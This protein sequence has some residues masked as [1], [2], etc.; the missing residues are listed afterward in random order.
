M[1]IVGDTSNGTGPGSYAHRL[2]GDLSKKV[3]NFRTLFA[4]NG[5]EAD[6]AVSKELVLQVKER[7]ENTVYGFFLDKRLVYPV[8]VYRFLEI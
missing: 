4:P 7:F 5:N 3:A 8:N 6:V 1:D 2:N